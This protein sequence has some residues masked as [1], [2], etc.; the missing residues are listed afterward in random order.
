MTA[1]GAAVGLGNVLRFPVLLARYG[2]LFVL[3]YLFFLYALGLPA[4]MTETAMGRVFRQSAVGCMRRVRPSLGFCGWASA[5]SSLLILCYYGVLFSFVVMMAVFSYQTAFCTPSEAGQ[6]FYDHAAGQGFPAGSLLFL[7]AAWALV[8]AC[9]GG[10]DKLGKIATV[11]VILPV[12]FLTVLAVGGASAH[13]DRL[14]PFFHI[15]P[16]VLRLPAF[17]CDAAGQVFFSLSLMVGV[18][19]AYGSYLSDEE[20]IFK[21]SVFIAAA[22]LAVSLLSGVVYLSFIGGETAP[23]DD[24]TACFSVYP[25]AIASFVSNPALRVLFAFFF[26]AGLGF[27]AVDSV[28]S[29][30]KSVTACLHDRFSVS[31]EK[32]SVVICLAAAL[33]G[34]AFLGKS[35]L[36]RLAA[37]DVAVNRVAVVLTGLFQF[38]AIGRFADLTA[39]WRELNQNVKKHRYPK[40]LYLFSVRILCPA[41]LFLLVLLGLA[42]QWSSAVGWIVTAA[43]FL[44][45]FLTSR[46]DKKSV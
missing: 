4:L 13:P 40:R 33:I 21:C 27:L 10:T 2:L 30:V 42:S 19:F 18:M 8:L 32:S 35:G 22:D 44:F 38:T 7:V 23:T 5:G 9:T 45:T 12:L 39:I 31:E 24:I 37:T 36:P 41:V 25:A 34:T 15:D 20:N 46:L 16:A 11:S 43:L 6:I 29:Y 17:W 26:Y 14:S 1:V 28:F 3:V